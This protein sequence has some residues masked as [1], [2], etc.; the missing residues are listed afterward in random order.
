MKF[1]DKV[2]IISMH[3]HGIRRKN[4][5]NDLQSAG[6]PED[7]LEWIVGIEGSML[8]VDE[9]L[10]EG[11]ISNKFIDKNGALTKSIYGCALSHRKAYKKFLETDDTIKTALIL[12]DDAALTHT[13]LRSLLN[14]SKGYDMLVDDVESINWGVI[15]VGGI[16]KK[17][18]S[19]PCCDAF[20]L[21]HM[22]RYPLG[23]AAHSYIINKPS[24][25]KLIENNTP[26][27]FAADCNIHCSDIE[28]YCTPVSHFG[29]KTGRYFRWDTI[30]Q[31]LQFEQHILYELDEFGSEFLSTT[32]FGDDYGTT[33]TKTNIRTSQIS[34]DI[35][36]EKVTFEPF[37]NSYGDVI[38]DWATIHLKTKKDE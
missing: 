28:L 22:D 15:M 12:E 25:Q 14:G 27:Q 11:T 31:M 32:T 7:R 18:D 2:Y 10:E 13:A 35:D 17:I 9:L 24:A 37:M 16:F 5:Y 21:N 29:Q 23:Y 4:L 20:V 30:N 8:N 36:I 33:N 26:I 19:K 6:F 34:E 1:V 3:K 38:K